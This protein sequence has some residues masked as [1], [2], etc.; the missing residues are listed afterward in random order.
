MT[1]YR[2][3]VKLAIGFKQAEAYSP[4]A[5][6]DVH[7]LEC[8]HADQTTHAGVCKQAAE[9]IAEFVTSDKNPTEGQS[10]DG[11]YLDYEIDSLAAESGKVLE[12][13]EEELEDHP[14]SPE[15]ALK[16]V[17]VVDGQEAANF[18]Q[19]VEVRVSEEQVSPE[20]VEKVK[21]IEEVPQEDPEAEPKYEYVFDVGIEEG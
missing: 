6:V 5:G 1:V 4:S 16:I 2:K 11:T 12:V 20:I 13:V 10:H 15:V 21:D 7:W 17:T 19:V 8:I 14:N 9:V 3:I 18:S